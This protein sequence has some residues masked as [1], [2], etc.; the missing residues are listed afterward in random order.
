MREISLIKELSDA[1]GPSGFEDD[2]VEIV[3]RE[4]KDFKNLK[5]DTLRNVRCE[6]N[7]N[8]G[9]YAV[10]LDSHLDEVGIIV[11]A[12]KPNGTMNFLTLGRWAEP[13]LP[14]SKF[15]VKNYEGK[16]VDCVVAAKPVHFMSEAD[17]K[18]PL[19]ISNMVLDCGAMDDKE[20][21][22][23][24][25]L[26]IASPGVPNVKCEYD[27][28]KKLFL[29]KAFDC[30]IGVAAEIEVMKRLQD[31]SLNVDVKAAFSAQ[32]EVGHRG[33]YNNVEQIKPKVAICF[34]GCPSDD[35]FMEP[36]MIQTALNKG[37]MLRNFDVSMITN[38][39]FQKYSID[40]ANKLNIP[41]QESVRSGGGTDGA[42]IHMKDVPTIVIGIPVRYIHSS[43]CYC[44]LHDY[45]AAVDLAVALCT[46]LTQDIID[47]F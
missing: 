8:D 23:Y 16:L 46:N 35:T 10:M 34:E 37:C 5:E 22:E 3:K 24:F 11:Q 26:K 41:V 42:A 14:S 1:F 12:I 32:E 25:K 33:A 45:N 4:L 47:T 36:Y 28:E 38:P 17:K 30:R 29:G 43:H 15:S 13:S 7:Q 31:K 20:V 21:K 44:T 18:A 39:R 27:E 9:K 19:S 2:V 6:L 40:L